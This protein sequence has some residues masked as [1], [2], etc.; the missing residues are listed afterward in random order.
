MERSSSLTSYGSMA[1][2]ALP[3]IS[4]FYVV[5]FWLFANVSLGQ[6][7]MPGMH[8]PKD[9]LFGIPLFV[10]IVLMLLSLAVA[11]LVFALG[12]WRRKL[13]QQVLAYVTCLILS[14]LLFRLD[15]YQVTTWIA[16]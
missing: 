9:I 10:H 7:A 11:P 4:Y 6:W 16:D 14:L 13:G 5:F 3:L 1:V 2:C 12:R 15:L 8:D